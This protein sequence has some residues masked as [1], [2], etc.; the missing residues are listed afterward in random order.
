MPRPTR[1]FWRVV[2]S[3]SG[4]GRMSTWAYSAESAEKMVASWQGQGYEATST[5]GVEKFD[6]DEWAAEIIRR[7]ARCE[8]LD[9]LCAIKDEAEE[10]LDGS[11]WGL[12]E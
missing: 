4:V 2:V 7:L 5:E 8:T 11:I 1:A 6:D 9:D 12:I 3:R 10:F